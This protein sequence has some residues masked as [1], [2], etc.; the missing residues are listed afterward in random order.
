LN[1]LSTELET[2]K[3]F[4]VDDARKLSSARKGVGWDDAF[5]PQAE[6]DALFIRAR[7]ASSERDPGYGAPSAERSSRT[8][9]VNS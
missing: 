6:R 4:Y 5:V 2:L 8:Q 3:S 9:S 7:A 1:F